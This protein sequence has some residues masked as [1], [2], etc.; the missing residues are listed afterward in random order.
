LHLS[1]KKCVKLKIGLN[2]KKW[3]NKWLRSDFYAKK[4]QLSLLLIF[5]PS[6]F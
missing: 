4:L 1:A 5:D 3:E 2:G 6:L